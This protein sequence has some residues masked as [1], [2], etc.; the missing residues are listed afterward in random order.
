MNN[1][2]SRTK[3]LQN[4]YHALIQQKETLKKSL[5]RFWFLFLIAVVLIV[6]YPFISKFHLLLDLLLVL[7]FGFVFA[8]AFYRLV[9][10]NKID[11]KLTQIDAEFYSLTTQ[12]LK[13]TAPV[14]KTK[15]QAEK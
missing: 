13:K 3:Y 8:L 1:S 10:L 4:Y 6:F 15:K 2:D 12:H 11:L 9:V 5:S 7:L 14:S